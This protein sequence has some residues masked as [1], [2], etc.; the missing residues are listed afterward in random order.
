MMMRANEKRKKKR[1]KILS[2]EIIQNRARACD[3]HI[4]IYTY[5]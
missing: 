2:R 3:T 4:Y 1:E 5:I